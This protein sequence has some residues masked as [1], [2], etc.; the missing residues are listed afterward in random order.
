MNTGFMNITLVTK[1]SKQVELSSDFIFRK[2]IH[3]YCL[4]QN[5]LLFHGFK[6]NISTDNKLRKKYNG[7][8]KTIYMCKHLFNKFRI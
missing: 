3:R 6:L 7:R 1:C 8:P 4:Y 5:L 2:I